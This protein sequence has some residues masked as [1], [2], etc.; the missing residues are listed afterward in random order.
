MSIYRWLLIYLHNR[1]VP[2]PERYIP[3]IVYYRY[4]FSMIGLDRLITVTDT[5]RDD[6]CRKAY[7]LLTERE[8]D[9]LEW[10]EL[11]FYEPL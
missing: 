2:A 11:K 8:L 9:H 3:P 7:D 6:A 1:L 10:A 5:N 4:T